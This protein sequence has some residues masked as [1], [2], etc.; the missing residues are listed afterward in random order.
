MGGLYRFILFIYHE[1]LQEHEENTSYSDKIG[2]LFTNA[3]MNDKQF[4]QV[5]TYFKGLQD[6]ICSNLETI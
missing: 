2:F 3:I 5:L 6:H 1:E 4:Q